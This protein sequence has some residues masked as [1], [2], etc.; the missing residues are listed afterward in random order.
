MQRDEEIVRELT[1]MPEDI[2][3]YITM[4]ML[5]AHRCGK[6]REPGQILHVYPLPMRRRSNACE[7]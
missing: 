1:A 6:V 2:R 4:G 5:A 7:A 3:V